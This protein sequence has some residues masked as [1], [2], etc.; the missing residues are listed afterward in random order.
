MTEFLPPRMISNNVSFPA[1]R[2]ERAEKGTHPRGVCR[3]KRVFW[4]ANPHL[5]VPSLGFVKL[6]GDDK[7]LL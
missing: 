7:S 4:R 5:T 2:R 1:A 3:A 6:A